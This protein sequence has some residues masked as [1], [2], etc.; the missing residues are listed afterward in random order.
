MS[1]PLS[2]TLAGAL[3]RWPDGWRW[4]DG[5]RE[6]R[7][8]DMLLTEIAPNFRCCRRSDVTYVEIPARWREARYWPGGRVDP[9]AANAIADLLAECGRKRAIY[10]EGLAEPLNDHRLTV[11]GWIVDVA[12]YDAVMREPCGAWWDKQHEQDILAHARALGWQG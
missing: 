8:R 5:T 9:D 10:A 7:I 1:A 2:K 11:D 6:P 3:E 12:Q 4:S